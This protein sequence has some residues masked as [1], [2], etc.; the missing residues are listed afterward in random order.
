MP[1]YGITLGYEKDTCSICDK[2][3]EIRHIYDRKVRKVVRVC[4]KCAETMS[5]SIK[6]VIEKYGEETTQEKL[7]ILTKEQMEKAGFEIK[8]K[9]TPE[10]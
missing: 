1:R 10:K 8:G 6:E 4:D 5:I 3:L 2:E 9:K 7:E